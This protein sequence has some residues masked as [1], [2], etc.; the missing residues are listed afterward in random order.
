MARQNKIKAL[1]EI[2]KTQ[3]NLEVNHTR[4]APNFSPAS[5]GKVSVMTIK[6][7]TMQAVIGNTML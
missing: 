5:S 4:S 6:K 3:S 7:M 1:A 2:I